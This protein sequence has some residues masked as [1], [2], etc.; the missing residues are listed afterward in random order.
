[1]KTKG[2]QGF[3]VFNEINDK[4]FP[5]CA[6]T[7]TGRAYLRN[8][9]CN[10]I[11]DRR[12]WGPYTVFT[13]RPAAEEFAR[14]MRPSIAGKVVVL[15]VTYVPSRRYIMKEAGQQRIHIK[16]LCNRNSCMFDAAAVAL[17][18]EFWIKEG[19]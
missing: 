4:L 13:S 6:H 11:P 15:P 14:N 8:N 10:K 17:A 3:K 16:E 19:T 12:K 7:P 18:E 2:K 1:M 9:Q 5:V